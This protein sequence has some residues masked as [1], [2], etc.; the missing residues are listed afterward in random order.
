MD[1]NST[2]Y[3]ELTKL[4]H[5]IGIEILS[6]PITWVF[7]IA[8]ITIYVSVLIYIYNKKEEN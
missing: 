3:W 1:L 8:I 2:S 6:R 5:Q 4:R 7:L